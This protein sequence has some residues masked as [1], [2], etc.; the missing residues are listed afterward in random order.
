[1]LARTFVRQTCEEN[2][3]PV[4]DLAPETIKSLLAHD[5]PGNV[6]ELKNLLESLVV[7]T[8]DAILRPEHLPE[9]L[10]RPPDAAAA[11]PSRVGLTLA[12]LERLH[13]IE[14]LASV[15]GNRT[16][17]AKLLGIGIRTLQ[18]KLKEYRIETVPAS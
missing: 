16:R 8:P 7:T 5:W 6:R 11:A 12:E 13:V 17:A 9:E 14:T 10:R 15:N 18:R 2:G 3:L 4:K 1:V